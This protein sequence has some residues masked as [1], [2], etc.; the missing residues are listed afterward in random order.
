MR[1]YQA[2][3]PRSDPR[4]RSGAASGFLHTVHI[5]S[6]KRDVRASP[7]LKRLIDQRR[8]LK[9][10]TGRGYDSFYI[11]V[12]EATDLIVGHAFIIGPSRTEGVALLMREIVHRHGALPRVIVDDRGPDNQSRWLKQFALSQGITLLDTM[13]A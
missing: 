4:M 7:E 2:A 12:D 13:T 8:A 1:A 6:S 3:A 10:D 9:D 11:A 5:D